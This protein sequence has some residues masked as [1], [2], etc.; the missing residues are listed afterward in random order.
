[1]SAIDT[2]WDPFPLTAAEGAPIK[3]DEAPEVEAV[4]EE[5]TTPKEPHAPTFRYTN[6]PPSYRI[7]AVPEALRQFMI[8]D[9]ATEYTPPFYVDRGGSTKSALRPIPGC[10]PIEPGGKALVF[11]DWG[12][13]KVIEVTGMTTHGTEIRGMLG[14]TPV[15]YQAWIA[16]K[17]EA[18]LTEVADP[19]APA[20]LTDEEAAAVEAEIMEWSKFLGWRADKYGWC[21]TF[22]NIL[23]DMGVTPWRPGFKT[24]TLEVNVRLNNAELGKAVVEKIGGEAEVR[25]AVV[26]TQVVI[27]DVSRDDYDNSRWTPLLEKAGYKNFTVNRVLAK[28]AMTP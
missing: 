1:M 21:G 7:G 28:E 18:P 9:V 6:M 13:P 15:Q 16:M 23:N 3:S 17:P 10:P 20:R 22:E 2:E 12:S 14:T 5:V 25:S 19:T 8:E 26:S 24:V 11:D 27:K 4:A